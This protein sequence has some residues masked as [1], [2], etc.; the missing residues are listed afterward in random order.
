VSDYRQWGV[1]VTLYANDDARNRLP[2]FAQPW[3]G[4]NPWD[5]GH[6]F[7]TNLAVY[8][9]TVPIWFCPTRPDEP[10]LAND[11]F[12]EWFQRPDS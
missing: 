4:L 6:G 10:Q 11:A 9:L 12:N 8:G 7:V 1:A 3:S 2:S 5:V